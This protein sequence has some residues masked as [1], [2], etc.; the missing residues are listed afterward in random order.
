MSRDARRI[1]IMGLMWAVAALALVLACARWVLHGPNKQLVDVPADEECRDALTRMCRSS[2]LILPLA[3]NDGGEPARPAPDIRELEEQLRHEAHALANSDVWRFVEDEPIVNIGGW[4]WDSTG[5]GFHRHWVVGNQRT[6]NLEGEFARTSNGKWNAKLTQL[7][8]VLT[9]AECSRLGYDTTPAKSAVIKI[10]PSTDEAR[11][12]LLEWLTNK[13]YM[14]QLKSFKRPAM[15]IRHLERKET[16]ASLAAGHAR[17]SSKGPTWQQIDGWE[18]E[19]NELR[20]EHVFDAPPSPLPYTLTGRLAL[21]RSNHWT[22]TWLSCRSAAVQ[23][24]HAN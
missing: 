10:V 24:A 19:N 11:D 21:S 13:G 20:F 17:S 16:A 5:V 2:G 4:K 3:A 18:L 7:R 9:R 1:T 6:Y 22:I 14:A 8:R 12:A 23:S 15:I